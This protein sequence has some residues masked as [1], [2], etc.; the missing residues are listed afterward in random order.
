MASKETRGEDVL[1]TIY[2]HTALASTPYMDMHNQQFSSPYYYSPPPGRC[3]RKR[4]IRPYIVVMS[5]Y[6]N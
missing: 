1:I 4:A 5:I 2:G 6:G 3:E